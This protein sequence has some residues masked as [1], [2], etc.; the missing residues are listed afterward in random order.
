[1]CQEDHEERRTTAVA[2]FMALVRSVVPDNV[3]TAAANMN[4]LG[5][6]SFSLFFGACLASLGDAAAPLI[7]V[8][9]VLPPSLPFPQRPAQSLA[10]QEHSSVICH[11]SA[12][13]I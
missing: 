1:M 3:F 11:L 13:V 12:T 10:L 2:A 5:I 9:Q 6:I 7:H 4:V 8:V